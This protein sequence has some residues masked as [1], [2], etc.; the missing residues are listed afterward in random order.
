MRPLTQAEIDTMGPTPVEVSENNNGVEK[1]WFF[2]STASAGASYGLIGALVSA[3]MDAIINAGPS[4][5]AHKS[6]DEM[7]RLMSVDELNTSLGDH[8]RTQMPTTSPPPAGV[9]FAAVT[10][11]QRLNATAAPDDAVL[12]NVEYTLSE[13]A[14]TLRVIAHASYESTQTP[15]TTPYTFKGSVPREQTRGPAYSNVFT[16]YSTQLPIPT[17]TPDL[18]ERLVASI[19]NSAREANGG[20]LPAEGTNEWKAMTREETNARDNNLTKDEIAIFLT[21]EWLKDDGVLLRQEVGRAHDFIARYVLLDMNRTAVPSITGQDELLETSADERT[22]RR[23]GAGVEAGSY[24]SSAGNVTSFSSY[25]NAIAISQA[26]TDRINTLRSANHHA[27]AAA[28][29]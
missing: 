22:V 24:V 26:N 4:Y 13:D 9:T 10:T 1:S 15:Y 14:S 27:A 3:V 2:T 29:H 18:Q 23:I 25:G 17:L 19:E 20:Q 16:Y 11:E 21:R 7:S 12:V 6:A 5:R 8:F 28:A